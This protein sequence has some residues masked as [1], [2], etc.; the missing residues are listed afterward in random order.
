MNALI[1]AAAE[2]Q[3]VCVQHD[4]RFCFIGG[5]AVQRWGEPRETVDVDLTLLTGFAD[6]RRY[7]AVLMDRFEARIDHAG[8]FVSVNRVLLLRAASGVGLDIALGGLPF[9]ELPVS[10]ASLFTYPPR[11]VVNR[12]QGHGA[13]RG[14][15]RAGARRASARGLAMTRMVADSHRG[16]TSRHRGANVSRREM[17]RGLTRLPLTRQRGSRARYS[18]PMNG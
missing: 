11:G 6:E 9:E 2:L 17:P 18:S 4:W 12:R 7:V 8:Q 16:S 14:R 1:L 5:L 10:R 3:A 15:S 13:G